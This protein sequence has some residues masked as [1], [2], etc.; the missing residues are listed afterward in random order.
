MSERTWS[1]QTRYTFCVAHSSVRS[2][3]KVGRGSSDSATA[4][5]RR[6]YQESRSSKDTAHVSSVQTCGSPTIHSE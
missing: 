5:K 2:N 1:S 3:V 6:A 4:S